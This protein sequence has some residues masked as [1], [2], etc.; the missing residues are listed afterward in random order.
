MY[1]KI[2]GPELRYIVVIVV[3]SDSFISIIAAS[4]R[5]SVYQ[6]QINLIKVSFV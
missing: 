5:P 1:I 4:K 3:L 2:R 6:I